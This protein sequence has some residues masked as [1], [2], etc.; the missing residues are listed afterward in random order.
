MD[1]SSGYDDAVDLHFHFYGFFM[2]FLFIYTHVRITIFS[3][4]MMSGWLGL[5]LLLISYIRPVWKLAD[6]RIEFY[7]PHK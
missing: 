3:A 2:D 4:W 6:Y 5:A 7:D 1:A